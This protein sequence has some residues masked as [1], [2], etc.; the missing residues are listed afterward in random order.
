MPRLP[1]EGCQ[2][3]PSRYSFEILMAKSDR[4]E[5]AISRADL[6]ARLAAIRGSAEAVERGGS[7]VDIG[8]AARC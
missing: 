4:S 3:A 2:P 6:A 8:A 1:A 5:A 7:S